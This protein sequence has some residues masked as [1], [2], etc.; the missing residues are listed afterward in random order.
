MKHTRFNAICLLVLGFFWLL[1]FTSCRS[2]RTIP[3][4]ARAE[5]IRVAPD[6]LAGELVNVEK[7]VD[8]PADSVKV[9]PVRWLIDKVRG[10]TRPT[11]TYPHA[12]IQS[13][14]KKSTVSI[15][16]APTTVSTTTVGKK[17]TGAAGPAATATTVSKPD[18]P[19]STDEGNATDNTKAGQRGGAAATAP[20]AIATATT[21]KPP[22]PW[23][24]YGLWAAGALGVYWLLLG[25]G[26][27]LLLALVRRNKSTNNLS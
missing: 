5:A 24:K 11:K 16:Q 19:V 13:I 17:G 15:Y 9:T 27:A 7:V 2:A 1:S 22:T 8:K 14:G 26:G 10:I 20:D 23:L 21:I 6:S 25:G 12:T 3:S 18:A 4:T